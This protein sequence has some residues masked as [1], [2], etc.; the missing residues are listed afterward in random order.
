MANLNGQ[1]Y[2]D[3]PEI[4]DPVVWQDRVDDIER[5]RLA[6]EW[7]PDDVTTLLDVGCGNGVFIN[8][9]KRDRFIV[10]ADLSRVALQQVTAPR[11]QAHAGLLPFNDIS[12]DASVCM[13]M[14]EHLPVSVY[15]IV[16][17]ELVR[18][19]RKYILISVPYNERLNYNS[20]TC[21]V[22]QCSFH[23]FNH[24]RQ[25]TQAEFETLFDGLFNLMKLEAVVKVKTEAW[26]GLWNLYR[27]YRH[28]HGKN[29]PNIIVCP[30]C[31]Y[32]NEFSANRDKQK[33]T[34]QI[35]HFPLH[36]LWP[37]VTTYKWWMALYRI[38]TR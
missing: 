20:V 10:G 23:S 16:L 27:L 11:L 33:S 37:K 3:N 7:L 8:Q 19:A 2:F 24:V 32:S 31:G 35:R 21:P 25:Y 6:I 17:E 15:Q 14:L 9:L 36:I 38:E 29:F 12:F 26:P 5:A 4:W 34:T 28:R 18:I 13:E 30:Q 1:S 22:C